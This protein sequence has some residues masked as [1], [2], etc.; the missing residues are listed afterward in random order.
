V[1]LHTLRADIDYGVGEA[2]TTYGVIGIKVW[3]YKGEVAPKSEAQPAAAVTAAPS[4]E[5]AQPKRAKRPAPRAGA[6]K[7]PAKEGAA[8]EGAKKP[9]RRASAK[10][11]EGGEG[12]AKP[13]ATV[14]RT[15]KIVK[16]E[17]APEG[18]GESKKE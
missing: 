16:D 5:P 6:R 3:V 12:A 14:K 2:K 15:R 8:T 9:G 13:K 18:G 7:A 4:E 17:T 11:A 1:P 10:T